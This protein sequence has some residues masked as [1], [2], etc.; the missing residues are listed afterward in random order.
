MGGIGRGWLYAL[1]LALLLSL[2][3]FLKFDLFDQRGQAQTQH[4][5]KRKRTPA[6][7]CLFNWRVSAK[8]LLRLSLRCSKSTLMVR[9]R[10]GLWR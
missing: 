10:D 8:L 3:L 5:N 6:A 1:L 7:G 4:K 2:I 9:L